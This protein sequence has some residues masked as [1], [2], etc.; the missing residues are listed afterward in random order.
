M[1]SSNRRERSAGSSGHESSAGDTFHSGAPLNLNQIMEERRKS[2]CNRPSKFSALGSS[3]RESLRSS[4]GNSQLS[5]DADTFNN[6]NNRRRGVFRRDSGSSHVGSERS[7]GSGSDNGF[8]NTESHQMTTHRRRDTKTSFRLPNFLA[9]TT[10]GSSPTNY[11]VDEK[12]GTSE[13]DESRYARTI[14]R[15]GVG[16]YVLISNHGLAEGT[17]VLVNRYGFPEGGGG[18]LTPEQRRGPYNFLLAKVKSV[19]F[20]EDAQ[21]YTVTRCDNDEEQ[22]ADAAW[23]EPIT[24]QI[25]I[26]AAK[27]AARKKFGGNYV[28]AP[29]D[30]IFLS[31]VSKATSGCIRKVRIGASLLHRKMKD[32]A[33]KCLSGRRPYKISFKFTGVNFLVLCSIWYLYIDQFRLAFFPHTADHTC[34]IVSW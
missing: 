32:Q 12:Q 20:E 1:S 10:T 33:S 4:G 26:D 6:G 23:M 13:G 11:D 30:N 28:Q 19:H 17:N 22:R 21:Y 14:R 2:R 25:G 18:A 34:A 5:H 29:I 15:Y 16:Q 8:G 27:A 7:G 3:L 9:Q 31:S 24:D